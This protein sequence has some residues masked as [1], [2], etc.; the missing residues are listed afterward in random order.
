AQDATALRLQHWCSDGRDGA[1]WPLPAGVQ[2]ADVAAGPEGAVA[3]LLV[4]GEER[5]LE[6]LELSQGM[7]AAT[8][9]PEA[10][11]D[12]GGVRAVAR[13]ALPA[14]AGSIAWRGNDVVLATVFDGDGAR[15][16]GWRA[17]RGPDAITW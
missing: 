2:V 6:V 10:H 13:L 3:L 8:A 15:T 1:G 4:H 7:S 14:G 11:R 9:A 12:G 16:Y 17:S 5:W